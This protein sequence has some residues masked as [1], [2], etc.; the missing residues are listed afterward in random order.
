MDLIKVVDFHKSFGKKVVHDG[1][2]FHLAKGECLG[3]IGGSGS[4]KS[5]LLRSLIG[6]E[7]PDSGQIIV[8]NVDITDFNEKQLVE[9]R[10][11]LAYVFQGGA[12]FDSMTVYENMAYPLR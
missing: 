6:L 1:V 10:K 2:D 11:K 7:K 3:L 4:G 5:V 12:L 8:D 9:I